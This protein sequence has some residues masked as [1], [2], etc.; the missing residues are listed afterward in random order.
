MRNFFASHKLLCIMIL[1][2]V[3]RFFLLSSVPASL[4]WDEVSMGYTAYSISQTGKDEWGEQMPLLFRSYGEWKSAVY[5]YLLVPFIKVLGLNAWAVRLPSAIAG[6]IAVYLTYLIGR[7]LYSDKVGLWAATLLA[8][9][10]WHLLLS[11]PAFEANVSLTLILAGI[12]LFL[13]SNFAW[14]AIFL[15]LAPHTYNSAKVVVPFLVIYLVW[16]TKLYKKWKEL[17]IFGVILAI[18]AAPL[19]MDLFSGRAQFRYTQVGVSTDSFALNEFVNMRNNVS[20][21][22]LISKLAFNKYTYSL[23]TTLSNGLSYL[24]PSF[25]LVQA[26]SHTQHHLP[27]FGVIYLAELIFIIFGM[28]HL[29]SFSK[30]NLRYLPFVMILLGIVPAAL[31]R[32]L[33]HVLRSILTLPGWQLLAGIG[34]IAVIKKSPKLFTVIGSLLLLQATIFLT[35]YFYWYPRTYARDWQYGLKEAATYVQEHEAEYDHI[36]VS[37]WFGETQ[38]FLAFYNQW[39]PLWYMNENKDNLEYERQGKLWLDQLEEYSIG[40]YTF[41]Y[42]KYG[43]PEKGK[44]L[45]VGKFDDFYENPKTLKTIYY[46]DGSVAV[47]IIG[48]DIK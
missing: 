48:G 5:I 20:I 41:K 6:V 14:S 12:N 2:A 10:P 21:P 7:K 39:D 23:H 37:K 36:V 13:S 47:H 3:L 8:I 44:T 40:K 38:L 26:G 45:Y 17:V 30:H 4:N 43:E 29:P 19:A 25:L 33:G 9:S 34:I 1:A 16:Q 42:I 24:N 32:D 18:F 15:G 35:A 46:P 11:R 31:T 27:Y 28:Y 22:P